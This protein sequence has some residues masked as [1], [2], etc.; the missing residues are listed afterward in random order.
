[1]CR[2]LAYSG[3]PVFLDRLIVRPE[4][5]L[6]EQSRDA[7]KA[8]SA[9]NADG[10]G[11]GWYGERGT[12]G[13]FRD[14]FPAWNDENLLNICEQ[15]KARLFFGHVRASTGSAINRANCHPFRHGKWLFMHNG[16]V[17]G[18]DTVRRELA[19]SIE[20]SFFPH[21]QGTTDSEIFFYLALTYGLD[22]DAE[23][24]LRR[25]VT[26]ILAV[27]GRA[28]IK[29]PFRL[30]AALTDGESVYALRYANDDKPPSLFYAENCALGEGDD[31]CIH[32]GGEACLIL[33]EPVDTG[34]ACWNEVPSASL[35]TVRN[36]QIGVS[37]CDPI[38]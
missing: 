26:K 17:G 18:F 33:S 32:S 15:T 23:T 27:T 7:H 6:V 2:W 19:M 5:S 11:I 30:T 12:P 22:D 36:G 24:A 14:V 31:T 20:P 8:K 28:G 16:Q 3:P 29:E 34:T 37:A 4:N 25:T 1:M 10:F 38:L 35:L 21:L 13:L 9:L